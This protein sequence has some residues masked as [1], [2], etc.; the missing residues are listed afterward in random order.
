[1]RRLSSVLTPSTVSVLLVGGWRA[2]RDRSQPAIVEQVQITCCPSDVHR[3]REVLSRTRPSWILLGDLADEVTERTA[4][5]S[6]AT[7]P[8]TKLA[9]LGP[10]DDMQRC[11]RWMRRGCSVYLDRDSGLKRVANTLLAATD[12]DLHIYSR[13]LYLHMLQV[14]DPLDYPALTSRQQQVL[15]LLSRGLSN[16]EIGS[17]LHVTQHTVEFHVRQLL[18]KFH[19]RNRLEVVRRAADI[20]LVA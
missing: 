14:H 3:L 17:A 2:I 6:R 19:A 8:Q 15:D 20:G 11:Q 18:S 5:C 12:G 13:T 7:S 4:T 10:D 9:M 1:M 16:S